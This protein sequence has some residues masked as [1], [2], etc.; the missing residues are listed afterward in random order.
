MKNEELYFEIINNLSD[1][2]YFVDLDRRITFWNKAAEEITGYK[3]EELIGRYCQSNLLNHIDREG[4][5]L[6]SVGCP[7]YATTLDGKQRSDEVFLRHKEGHRI[8]IIVNIFPIRENGEV[9]GAVEIFTPS[10]PIVYEDNLIEKLS[11]MAM[12]DQLTGISNRRKMESYI[13]YRLRELKRFQRSFC[14]I[15]LDID[16]FSVFNNT[17]GHEAGDGV[18]INV[19]KS[20]S[21]SIRTSDLF[22]RWGGEEFVGVL[23]IK[24]DE[25]ALMLAEKIRMLVEGSEIFYNQENLSVT[26]SVGVTIAREDDTVESAVGRADALMYESKKKNKNCVSTDIV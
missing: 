24:K 9:V 20:I 2:V 7:L 18:L 17:H 23:E 15:F 25:E 3:E 10:S 5:P 4:R 19:S 11:N 16:N 8:P 12:S 14:V 6:C 26:A 22:G 21:R 13:E 1:G